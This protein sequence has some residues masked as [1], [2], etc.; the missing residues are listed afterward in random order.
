MPQLKSKWTVPLRST[1]VIRGWHRVDSV[2][3]G[4]LL[5]ERNNY[6]DPEELRTI[7]EM[8]FRFLKQNHQIIKKT[9]K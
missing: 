6:D 5:I 9:H 2:A 8:K 4:L 3:W 1:Y 7:T